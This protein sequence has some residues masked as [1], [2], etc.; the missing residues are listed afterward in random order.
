L[1]TPFSPTR[2]AADIIK[3]VSEDCL[4]AELGKA[5]P[6]QVAKLLQPLIV[7]MFE[8]SWLSTF[9]R[10]GHLF[11][12][13]K[14]TA[15]Q[16]KTEAYRDVLISD[17]VAKAFG[18]EVRDKVHGHALQTIVN[19][20]YGSGFN[21]GAID[22]ATL[23]I[24][25]IQDYCKEHRLSFCGLFSDLS[26]AFPSI[27]RRLAVGNS[28]TD[29]ELC[30]RLKAIGFGPDMIVDTLHM[31]R[32]LKVWEKARTPKQLC[33]ILRE[34][35]GTTWFAMESLSGATAYTSGTS[36]GTALADIIFTVAFAA[37]LKSIR[38]NLEALELIHSVEVPMGC[39]GE[40]EAIHTK[41]QEISYA[42][43]V[44]F[45]IVADALTLVNKTVVTA[46]VILFEFSKFGLKMNLAPGKSSA[47]FD[48]RGPKSIEA[49]TKAE[50]LEY[51]PIEAPNGTIAQLDRVSIQK[52]VGS[53]YVGGGALMPE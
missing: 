42:D 1:H 13:P 9:I 51:I 11:A 12:L 15:S 28:I 53:K 31:L 35:L 20:Q 25:A 43:D 27:V 45:P 19:T 39:F 47:V 44:V 18:G 24:R 21:G 32:S 10:G 34:T 23:H 3:A 48:F 16:S 17:F 33:A 40:T 29:C 50:R 7:K 6:L 2:E 5:A 38:C 37:V 22:I 26:A 46:E 36:A 52:H 14:G 8:T 41:F 4:G 49:R 30:D